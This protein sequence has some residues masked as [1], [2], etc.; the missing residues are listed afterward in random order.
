MKAVQFKLNIPKYLAARLLSKRLKSIGISPLSSLS[1]VE[2]PI[3]SAINDQWLRIKTIRSGICATDLSIINGT[4]NFSLEPYGS[5]EFVL[6]HEIVGEIVEKSPTLKHLH[7]GD[8]VVIE[9]TLSCVARGIRNKCGYCRRGLPNLC[10]HIT[11]GTLSPAL[12]IGFNKNTGGGWGEYFIAH[13]SQVYKL[14]KG[15]SSDEGVFVEPLSVALH[16]VLRRYPPNR[17]IALIMGTGTI[18]LL[19]IAAIRMLRLRCKIIATGRYAFQRDKASELGANVVVDPSN[20]DIYEVVARE[21]KARI[22]KPSIGK[23]VV[24][25]GVHCVYDTIATNETIDDALR[26]TRA[27][28]SVVLVGAAGTLRGVNLTPVWFREVDLLG[29]LIYGTEQFRGRRRKTFE[30]ALEY[31]A[32]NKKLPLESLITHQF[33]LDQWK[34]AIRAAQSRN[35]SKSIKVIFTME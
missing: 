27:G 26:L 23:R 34:Q 13:E 24:E 3:P 12:S 14:P 7:E 8:R 15:I 1:L 25:G 9:P 11:D 5:D 33:R 29:S 19:T 35:S 28:G 18:G 30:M 21:T 17:G 2:M 6:G 20:E 31:L 10:T 4:T 16:T 32:R 22:F